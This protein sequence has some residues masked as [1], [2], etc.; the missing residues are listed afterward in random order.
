MEKIALT[1]ETITTMPNGTFIQEQIQILQEDL[2]QRE[3]ERDE[4]LILLYD[5]VEAEGTDV[6][7]VL[8]KIRFFLEHQTYPTPY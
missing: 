8:E 7:E 5:V 6:E 1:D 4:M 2:D 3:L